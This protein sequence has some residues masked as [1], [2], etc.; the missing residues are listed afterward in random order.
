MDVMKL[1]RELDAL[2]A[3]ERRMRNL[4]SPSEVLL[5]EITRKRDELLYPEKQP[6]SSKPEVRK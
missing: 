3:L 6:A 2:D 1:K 4:V 5:K